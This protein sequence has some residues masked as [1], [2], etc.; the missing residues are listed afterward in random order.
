[1]IISGSGRDHQGEVGHEAE[2]L[3]DDAGTVAGDQTMVTATS[4]GHRARCESHE[5]GDPA[6]YSIWE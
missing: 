5:Q 2:D 6:P 3:V 1:M 4:G